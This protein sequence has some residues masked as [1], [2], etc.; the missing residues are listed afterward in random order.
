MDMNMKNAVRTT[1][2]QLKSIVLP[3]S[4][5]CIENGCFDQSCIRRVFVPKTVKSIGLNA[6]YNCRNLT[7]VI[8]Q[9]G[10]ESIG[11][12]CFSGECDWRGNNNAPQIKEITIP[13]TVK[14]IGNGAF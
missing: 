8:L 4:I 3:Y 1:T 13:R 5:E 14:S 2:K 6:F 12:G 11:D 10:L 9:E 7:S